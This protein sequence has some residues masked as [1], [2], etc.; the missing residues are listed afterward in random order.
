LFVL[1]AAS[2]VADQLAVLHEL[3]ALR[4][5]LGPHHRAGADATIQRHAAVVCLQLADRPGFAAHH[6]RAA[7]L[8][9]VQSNWVLRSLATVWDGLVALLD[10][11][12]DE[13]ER[14]AWDLLERKDPNFTASAAGLLTGAHRWRGTLDLTTDA[15]VKFARDSPGLP[16]A[17]SIAATTAAITGDRALATELLDD[18]LGRPTS[19]VDDSTY[20]AQLAVLTEACVLTERPI[21]DHVID[22]L[23]AFSGQLLVLSWG[24]EV[25]GAAD[26]YMAI[27][28]AAA[29]DRAAA[30]EAFARAVDLEA[31]V[32]DVLPLRTLVWRS[33]MLGDV[34]PTPPPAHLGG[35]EVEAAALRAVLAG[36]S[37]RR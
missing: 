21:P 12:P 36:A 22:A 34:E 19:I 10:G 5:E 31:R 3:D 9:T 32:S 27:A 28:R 29:G 25:P 18:L 13:A 35:L 17:T 14:R 15:I 30:G 26:R 11:M 33:A 20:A 2:R 1:N 24:V 37:P 23:A 16:I 6:A 8:A 7:E 4:D